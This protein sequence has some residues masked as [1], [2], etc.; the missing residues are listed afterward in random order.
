MRFKSYF[1][2]RQKVAGKLSK[3]KHV[4][5][6]FFE[7]NT[8]YSFLLHFVTKWFS[9]SLTKDKHFFLR[10]IFQNQLHVYI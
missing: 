7:L 4:E 9:T 8:L 10:G 6:A 1:L 3:I 2:S 5:G